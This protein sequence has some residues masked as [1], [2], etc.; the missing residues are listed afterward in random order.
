MRFGYPE[1]RL[2]RE[3]YNYKDDMAV[4]VEATYLP[5]TNYIEKKK[6]QEELKYF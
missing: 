1:N 3:Y 4:S 5:I 2:E 6:K